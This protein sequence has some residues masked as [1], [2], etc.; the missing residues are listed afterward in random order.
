MIFFWKKKQDTSTPGPSAAEEAQETSSLPS[1]PDDQE[2]PAPNSTLADQRS[3]D[4][5]LVSAEQAT[6]AEQL[7]GTQELE[8]TDSEKPRGLFGRLKAAL[9][10]RIRKT[11]EEIVGQI[12]AAIKAAGKVDENLLERIEEILIRADVGAETTLKIIEEMREFEARGVSADELIEN[13]KQQLLRIVGTEKHL[14]SPP[15]ERPWVILFV[16]VNGTG[17]TTTIGKLAA[18]FG[19]KGLRC[20]LVA[21]DTFRAA[22]I[23]QLGIWAQRTGA[24]FLAKDMGADPAGVAYDALNKAIAEKIDVVLIDTAGRLHTKTNLMEELKKVVRVVKKIIPNAPHDTLLVLDATT[25]QN[26]IQQAR[27]F[28]EAI[29]VTGLVM[30][31]LDGTAKGGVLIGIRNLFSIPVVKIGVGEGIDDLRDFDPKEFVDALFEEPEEIS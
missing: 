29:P 21:G 18:E 7:P 28:T 14:L 9:S 17:K 26:A 19:A 2:T 15:P 10:Q 8:T 30:T 20:L 27:V 1:A 4:G 3:N 23:E 25:G 31:K 12:K 5:S 22:A 24:E 6:L 16:G 11:R 13:F